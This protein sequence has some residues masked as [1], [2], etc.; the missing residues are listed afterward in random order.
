MRDSQAIVRL[1][2]ASWVRHVGPLTL[3]SLVAFVPWLAVAFGVGFA[4]GPQALSEQLALGFALAAFAWIPQ[5]G[6]VAAAAPLVRA[7]AARDSV[8]FRPACARGFARLFAALAPTITIVLAV[9][10]GAVALVVPGCILL[11]LFAGAT[12]EASLDQP[13]AA[14]LLAS[15]RAA[16]RHPRRSIIVIA[17]VIAIDLVL[18]CAMYV[19]FARHRASAAAYLD[20]DHARLF[21]RAL[22]LPLIVVSPLCACLVAASRSVDDDAERT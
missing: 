3:V 8:G 2:A 21:T 4:S 19:V 13:V 11:V 7:T 10:T 12:A 1:A 9:F 22:V 15:A 6:V 16:R 18:A 17:S 5:L 20:L 14:L